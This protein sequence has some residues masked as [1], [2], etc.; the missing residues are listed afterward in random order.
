M[1]LEQ[2]PAVRVERLS[3]VYRLY[4]KPSDRLKELMLARWHGRFSRDFW[5][6]HDVSF[7]L[8]RGRRLGVIGRNGS[9][10]STLLQILAGTLAPTAGAADIHG[11]VAAL[12]ELGSGF[13]PDYTGREN[14]YLNASILGLNQRETDERFEAIAAFADIGEFIEQPVKTYSSGMFVRLAFA[15]ATSVDADVLLVDEALAV[16]DVF[17]TQKCFRHLGDLIKRGVSI[18]MVTQDAAVVQQVCD[19]VLVLDHGHAIFH[20]DTV[21]GVRAYHA[22]QRSTFASAP[23]AASEGIP[24]PLDPSA[25]DEGSHWPAP[26]SFLPLDSLDVVG[27]GSRCTAIALCDEKGEARHVFEM[28]QA[29]LFFFEFIV[30]EPID[31]P[32]GGVE[33]LNE[34]NLVLHGKNSIQFELRVPDVALRGTRLRFR[35]RMVLNIAQGQYSFALGLASITQDDLA[36]AREVPYEVLASRLRTLLVV[37]NAGAFSV[38]PRRLGQALPYHGLCN[39]DGD[40]HVSILSAEATSDVTDGAPDSSATIGASPNH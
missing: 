18:I 8:A 40:Q 16:G 17:F 25:S 24:Q 31:A 21:A 11:R 39:L 19:E 34:R 5:A 10:K 14:V 32:I 35:Q 3:K 27:I 6:L 4:S 22:L 26:S 9:G 23:L 29:A 2:V 38:V 33:I 1:G 28:G 7:E 20:G 30:D 37:S 36:Q 12:L 13:N 15:V